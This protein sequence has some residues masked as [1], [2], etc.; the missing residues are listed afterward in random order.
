MS[1]S[2]TYRR[3]Q[4]DIA[5]FNE[6]LTRLLDVCAPHESF[7]GYPTWAPQ[8]GKQAEAARRAAADGSIFCAPGVAALVNAV[9]RPAA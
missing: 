5:A 6:A 3:R 7:A 4:H 9:G 1:N 8:P 2:K